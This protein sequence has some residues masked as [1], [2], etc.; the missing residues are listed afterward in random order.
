MGARGLIGALV[1]LAQACTGAGPQTADS[2]TG[3]KADTSSSEQVST[4]P[5]PSGIGTSTDGSCWSAPAS[6]LSSGDIALR[7]ATEEAGVIQPL[8]GMHGHAMAFGDVNADGWVDLFVG[9]FAD[10]EEED[11]QH[12][13][14]SG[15]SPERLLLGGPGGFTIDAGFPE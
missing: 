11:Y 7:D 4:L 5:A 13:G 3:T 10:R 2:G 9:T 12:R 15:A 6:G 14:A 1:L 8:V